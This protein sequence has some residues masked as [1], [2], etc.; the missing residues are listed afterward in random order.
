M[1][2]HLFEHRIKVRLGFM[3]VSATEQ[4]LLSTA[5]PALGTQLPLDEVVLLPGD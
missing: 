3:L 5:K 2:L 4:A 1:G